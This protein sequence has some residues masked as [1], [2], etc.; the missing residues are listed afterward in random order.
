M[1]GKVIVN[2]NDGEVKI[3]NKNKAKIPKSERL[4]KTM[5]TFYKRMEKIEGSSKRRELN[6]E[7]GKAEN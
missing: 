5:A 7:L 1:S 4:K 3:K 2:C 6:R